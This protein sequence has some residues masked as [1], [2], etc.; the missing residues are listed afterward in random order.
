MDQLQR[1]T[2]AG[3]KTQ[4]PEKYMT[5]GNPNWSEGLESH[6]LLGTYSQM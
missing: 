6:I 2:S 3:K 4:Q 1:A 5:D